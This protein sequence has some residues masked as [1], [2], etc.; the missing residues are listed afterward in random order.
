MR[1]VQ[2]IS[3]LGV[4]LA[5]LLSTPSFA[6]G[7]DLRFR[8]GDVSI[9]VD[10]GPPPAPVVEYVPVAVPGYVWAPGYWMFNGHRHVWHPGA[11][12]RARPGHSHVA[13]HWRQIGGRWYLESPRW[14]SQGSHWRH[15]NARQMGYQGDHD[16]GSSHRRSRG[17]D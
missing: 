8:I 12:T 17:H 11:W 7:A 15:G 1:A 13:G 14:E 5:A 6:N 3:F 4:V 16:H 9:D 2:Q 10:I